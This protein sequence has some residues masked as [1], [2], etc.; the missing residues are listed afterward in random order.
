MSFSREMIRHPLVVRRLAVTA[1]RELVPSIV[2]VTLGGDELAGFAAEGPADHMKVFFPDPV[3]G[4]LLLPEVDAQGLRRPDAAGAI[5]SRDYTPV[6]FRPSTLELDVDFVIHGDDGPA[7]AWAGRATPGDELGIGGPRGS[8]LVPSGI[9]R[10]VIVAD[11]TSLPATR[12]WLGLLPDGIPVTG[13]F[14]VAD[15]SLAGYF[16]DDP[17]LQARLDAEWLARGDGPGQ[18]DE[19]LRSLGPIDDD[20]FVFLAGEATTLAPLRRYLRRELGLPAEQVSANGYWKRGIVN[21]DHH[22][23]VDPSDPD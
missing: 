11:E 13:L 9:G 3:S 8:R 23:P 16:A 10:L 21:F 6:T 20:T 19:A 22:A 18:L 14:D 17:G 4:E 5:I 2:R 12:R 7:S 15:E 1:T